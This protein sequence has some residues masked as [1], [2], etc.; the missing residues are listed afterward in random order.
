MIVASMMIL[1]AVR[2]L[3]MGMRHV[4]VITVAVLVLPTHFLSFA[5]HRSVEMVERVR[6]TAALRFPSVVEQ[7]RRS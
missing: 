6:V 1:H 5:Y 2:E 7:G 4:I 3:V